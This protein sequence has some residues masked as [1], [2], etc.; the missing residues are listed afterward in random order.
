MIEVEKGNVK[1]NIGVGDL[2]EVK[3]LDWNNSV[4]GIVVETFSNNVNVVVFDGVN[5]IDDDEVYLN[6]RISKDRTLEQLNEDENYRL[7]A[8]SKDYN[9][10]ITY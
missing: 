10:K 9:I 8:K 1:K 4:V 6:E 5:N 3:G 2:V 7:L